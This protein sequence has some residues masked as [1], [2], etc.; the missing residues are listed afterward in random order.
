M[1]EATGGIGPGGGIP[2]ADEK[3][4]TVDGGAAVAGGEEADEL[5]AD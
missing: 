3:E 2:R 1:E 5:P 4:A